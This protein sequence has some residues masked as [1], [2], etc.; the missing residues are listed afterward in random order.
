MGLDEEGF[1]MV[2]SIIL[3]TKPIPNMNRTYA[4]IVQQERVHTITHGRGDVD[5]AVAFTAEVG[6]DA[7]LGNCKHCG[8]PGHEKEGYFQLIGYPEW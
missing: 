5:T 1:G 6:C 4:M 3:S 8:R 7:K 2:R